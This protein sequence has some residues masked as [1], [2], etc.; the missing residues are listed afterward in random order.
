MPYARFN[1]RIVQLPFGSCQQPRR[2]NT[3]PIFISVRM[4][5]DNVFWPQPL[6]RTAARTDAW[7]W[8]KLSM[9]F[10]KNWRFSRSLGFQP[11]RS[12][13]FHSYLFE[14]RY[15]VHQVD[16]V[17][18]RWFQLAFTSWLKLGRMVASK[19]TFLDL[20]LCWLTIVLIVLQSTSYFFEGKA[21]GWRLSLG[22]VV[23]VKV[24]SFLYCL[25]HL[26]CSLRKCTKEIP[27]RFQCTSMS[28]Y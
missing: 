25:M 13:S 16:Q 19:V 27:C 3:K 8:H 22:V 20:G 18:N 6:V 15:Q 14:K 26:C 4:L 24:F 28:M 10:T 11:I 12:C 21:K 1:I 5:Q 23:R 2:H 7:W 17:Q 9:L